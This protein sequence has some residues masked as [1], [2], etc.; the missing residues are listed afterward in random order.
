MRATADLMADLDEAA[1]RR[2]GARLGRAAVR[3][4]VFVA[5]DG[6]LGAGKTSLVQ[7]ACRGAGVEEVVT[8][9]TFTLV[10]RYRTARG[11]L[12][13]ADLYRI[14]DP[15]ELRELGWEDLVA[16]GDPV[17][18]EWAEHAGEERLPPDRWEIRLGIPPG[19]T[20]RRIAVRVLGGAPAVP[21][22][23]GDDGSC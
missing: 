20:T 12:Y 5:L 1:L 15:E 7:A 19:G 10:N 21:G 14:E 18:V 6:P 16:G 3:E 8:S 2:W 23:G 17:F 11:H 22:F 9:P 13:H 4:G